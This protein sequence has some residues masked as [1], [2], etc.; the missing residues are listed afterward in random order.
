MFI[1]KA[2]KQDTQIIFDFIQ[3]KA[4]F[5]GNTRGIPFIVSTTLVKIEKTLFCETPFAH[6]LLLKNEQEVIG[7]AL[8]Y[9]RYSSFSG[10]PSI[11]LDD[12]F[13]NEEERSKGGGLQ[14]MNAI[15]KEA[16]NIQASHLYWTASINNLK[17]QQFYQQF[18]AK[19]ER[20]DD[21]LLY[22]KLII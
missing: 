6:V 21:S 11:W 8:Y 17:A 18:G 7:F 15:I 10:S 20:T 19:I 1:N 3:K 5:D 2:I 4:I 22:Y 12:L 13:I 14:L 16:A 9:F